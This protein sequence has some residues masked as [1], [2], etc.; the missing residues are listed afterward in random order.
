MAFSSA[1]SADRRLRFEPTACLAARS[2]G[3]ACRACGAACPTAG[4]QVAADMP[5]LAGACIGCGRC[6]AA[7][8]TG[9]LAL[10][11]F[12]V[13][14]GLPDGNQALR[15]DCWM[16]PHG[17][18]GHRALRAPCLGGVSPGR[19][20]AWA[21]AAGEAPLVVADRGWCAAC[22]AR[23]ADEQRH[24]A[25]AALEQVGTWLRTAGVPEARLPRLLQEPLPQALRPAE[26]PR[27][28]AE[29]GLSRRGFLRRLAE[30][31][32]DPLRPPRP[33]SASVSALRRGNH[34]QP[35][36]ALRLAVLARLAERWG[37]R[38]HA[39]VLPALAVGAGCQGHG[40][41]AHACPTGA[42]MQAEGS[43]AQGL[44]FAAAR[45]VACRLCERVCPEQAIRL[46]P[47]RAGA[48]AQVLLRRRALRTCPECGASHA[49][50]DP[51]CARCTAN[52][53]LALNLFSPSGS[54][55]AASSLTPEV[56]H[57]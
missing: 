39:D 53:R 32:A 36:H 54:G 14:G 51:L 44:V 42:L 24:A 4:L 52:R 49:G 38:V 5:R 40:V 56:H 11:G 50:T 21:E 2:A 41:C 43:A 28:A 22:P 20:L 7:C 33:P 31:A 34:E 23:H 8:P 19:W 18:S 47:G 55:R 9:A 10:E 27:P 37:G 1:L 45:C 17:L 35:E 3:A 15:V 13:E 12:E 25:A 29:A 46:D 30:C 57:E 6:A 26:L 16:V 48:T